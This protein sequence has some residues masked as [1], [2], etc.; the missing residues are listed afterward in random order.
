MNRIQRIVISAFFVAFASVMSSACRPVINT[1]KNLKNNTLT[2]SDHARAVSAV[3]N[4]DLKSAEGF[5]TGN[6]YTHRYRP[7]SGAES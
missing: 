6:L 1:A 5:L 4:D 2:L 7:I 3:D